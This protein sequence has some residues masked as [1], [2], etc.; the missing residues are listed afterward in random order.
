MT[1]DHCVGASYGECVV[2][3]P[4]VNV[5]VVV[6]AMPDEET[7]SDVMCPNIA[8]STGPPVRKDWCVIR[9]KKCGYKL[10]H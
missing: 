2:P 5:I 9:K 4:P 3:T 8:S 7:V 1:V 10:P 6:W